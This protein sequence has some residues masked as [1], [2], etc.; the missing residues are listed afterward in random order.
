MVEVDGMLSLSVLHD[1]IELPIGLCVHVQSLRCFTCTRLPG[2]SNRCSSSFLI[3]RKRRIVA[4]YR[5]FRKAA[6]DSFL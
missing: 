6:V 4:S 1:K 2:R 3:S 5:P